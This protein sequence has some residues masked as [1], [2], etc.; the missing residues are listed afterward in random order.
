MKN[1]DKINS[2]EDFGK[3]FYNQIKKNIKKNMSIN[4]LE[5]E[6]DFPRNSLNNYKNGTTPSVNRVLQVAKYFN[7]SME[8]L[9]DEDERE[10]VLV[11]FN[12]LEKKQKIKMCQICFNWLI[13]L[14]D[15]K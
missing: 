14:K 2:N 3:R 5:R 8:S 12:K 13:S 9:L 1:T 7:V 4:K 15:L 10:M 11:Y 6:L